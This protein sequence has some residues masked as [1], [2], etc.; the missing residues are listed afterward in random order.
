M[1][2][3]GFDLTSNNLL[4]YG[5]FNRTLRKRFWANKISISFSIH[6]VLLSFKFLYN[7]HILFF[8]IK[9][10][11][12]TCIFFNFFFIYSFTHE[13]YIE[14]WTP[15]QICGVKVFCVC[16][17]HSR[18]VAWKMILFFWNFWIV[19]NNSCLRNGD[20]I[21]QCKTTGSAK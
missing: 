16:F 21:N 14:S 8:L 7:L 2:D 5:H 11:T 17:L 1:S 20:T 15:Q 9:L 6:Y 3:P 13:K 4:E 19:W 10:F 18:I 12:A